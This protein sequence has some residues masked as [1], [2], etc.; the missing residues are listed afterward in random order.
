MKEKKSGMFQDL[1]SVFGFSYVKKD[2]LVCV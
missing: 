1:K 2:V